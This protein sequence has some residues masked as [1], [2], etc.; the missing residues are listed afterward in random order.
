MN[1]YPAAQT[2]PSKPSDRDKGRQCSST[3]L[4]VLV[5]EAAG[6]PKLNVSGVAKEST[7]QFRRGLALQASG[8][9]TTLCKQGSYVSSHFIAGILIVSV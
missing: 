2:S 9:L 8:R 4:H 6:V 7:T 3:L 1:G 5:D